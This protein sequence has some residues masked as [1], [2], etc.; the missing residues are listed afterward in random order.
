LQPSLIR[1]DQSPVRRYRHAVPAVLV[2]RWF[3]PHGPAPRRADP[4]LVS[5]PTGIHSL[6][7][8]LAREPGEMQSNIPAP[9]DTGCRSYLRRPSGGPAPSVWSWAPRRAGRGQAPGAWRALVRN[10][11]RFML[12]HQQFRT[13][14]LGRPG[15]AAPWADAGGAVRAARRCLTNQ[16]PKLRDSPHRPRHHFSNAV[17]TALLLC[18]GRRAA[19]AGPGRGQDRPVRPYPLP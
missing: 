11:K 5:S 14:D 13:D 17:N 19:S 8:T 6:W 2:A 4:R 12:S 16:D 15:G 18:R 7:V 10:F 9:V 1:P 3:P